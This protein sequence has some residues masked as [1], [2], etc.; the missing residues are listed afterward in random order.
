MTVP[1]FTKKSPKPYINNTELVTKFREAGGRLFHIH[2]TPYR[3][4]M[5][6][7]YR[8]RSGHVEVATAITHRADCF[9]K[10]IGTKTAIEHF[11]DGRIISVPK[12]R[13]GVLSSLRDAFQ[14][15]F[16]QR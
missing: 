7:A 16:Y 3:R 14:Y 12:A 15:N 4:G 13:S 9:E 10:K 11:N 1:N 5:T 6:I 8:E 2:P